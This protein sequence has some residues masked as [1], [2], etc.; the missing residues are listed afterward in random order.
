MTILKPVNFTLVSNTFINEQIPL[1]NHETTYKKDDELIYGTQIYKCVNDNIKTQNPAKDIKNFVDMGAIN[2]YRFMDKYINTQSSDEN[3]SEIILKVDKFV[4]SIA[5]FNINA[6]NVKVEGIDINGVIKFSKKL[7]L[8]Y[9]KSRSWW[10]YF[11][12]KWYF[13]SDAVIEFEP[14]VG[15]IKITLKKNKIGSAL[16]HVILGNNYFV[17]DT[18]Y[19]PK[20]GILDYSKINANEWGDKELIKGKNAKYA[21]ISIAVKNEMI[22]EVR[23]ELSDIAGTLALFIGDERSYGYDSLNIFGF[24]KDFNIII[25][26]G[27]YSIC[28]I[29]V[30]GII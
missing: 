1:F 22:D 12:G 6:A 28:Q 11:F 26:D 17:G 8:T 5:F 29:S 3:D 20:V 13:K 19:S 25:D 14:F 10:E 27:Q 9:K 23:R 4:S 16:G 2:K 24:Y 15:N 18:I 21:D 7:N 30:E